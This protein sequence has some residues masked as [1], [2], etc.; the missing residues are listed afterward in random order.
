MAHPTLHVCFSATH[1][2]FMMVE[3]L[4]SVSY[5]HSLLLDFIVSPETSTFDDFLADYLEIC[6]ADWKALSSACEEMG[7]ELLIYSGT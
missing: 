6:G 4:E 5:D 2:H 1:L 7:K 3:F